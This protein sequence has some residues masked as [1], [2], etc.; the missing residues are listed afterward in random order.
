MLRLLIGESGTGKT[1]RI[2]E[3]IRTDISAG[4]KV[5]LIVPEQQTVAVERDMANDLPSDA[6][7]YFEAT[8][9]TRLCDTVFRKHGGL[10]HENIDPVAEQLLMWR[11]LNELSQLP[12]YQIEAEPKNIG[13]MCSIL[14]ELR[15]MKMD[16]AAL[17]LAAEK[18]TA[19]LSDKLR[20]YSLIFF[21]YNALL[22]E[23]DGDATDRLDKLA[24]QLHLHPF[25]KNTRFYIDN[26]SSYTAQEYAVIDA[27]L[28]HSD[29]T[30]S[31][32]MP[33]HVEKQ[34]S[35]AEVDTTRHTLLKLAGDRGVQTE[36]LTLETNHRLTAPVRAYLSENLFL[37]GD[38]EA[39]CC[40]MKNDP[41]LRLV[42]CPD[43]QDSCDYIASDISRRVQD[44]N[45][46]YS[47]F[48]II[49]GTASSYAGILDAALE[50][51]RVPFFFSREHDLMSFEPIKMTLLAYA[52]ITGGWRRENVVAYLKCAPLGIPDDA[53]DELELYAEMWNIQGKRWYDGKEWTMGPFGF[54]TPHTDGQKAYA[55][56]KLARVNAA[57]DI[58]TPALRQLSAIADGRH[59]VDEHIR[60][61]TSY[62]MSLPQS[63]PEYLDDRS[64]Q[65]KG[66]DLVRSDE[67]ARL[68][69]IICDVLDTMSKYLSDTSLSAEDFVMLLKMIFSVVSL[70]AIPARLDEVTVGEARMQRTGEV[71]HVYLLGANEGEFPSPPTSG[72]AFNDS[73]RAALYEAGITSF[74]AADISTSRELFS[75]WRAMNTASE[76]TTVIWSSVGLN[77]ES[78]TP[79]D[80]V[81]RM[82]RLL[83][84]SYPVTHI[85]SEDIIRNLT[86]P[87]AAGERIGQTNGTAVGDALARLLREDKAYQN[88]FSAQ[89]IPLCNSNLSLSEDT[90]RVQWPGNL[91]MTQSHLQ[92]LRECPFAFYCSFVLK[93]NPPKKAEFSSSSIGTFLHAVLENFF[94]EAKL[95]KIDL[96]NMDDAI[97]EELLMHAHEYVIN[98]TL[99]KDEPVTPR[100]KTL[101]S[102][103]EKHARAVISSLIDEMRHSSFTPAF[104]ELSID[105]KNPKTPAPVAFPLPDNK[106]IYV[107]GNIDRVDT[108]VEND[109][110]YIRVVDYKTGSKA[111]EMDDI[112][113]GLNLQLFLYMF[114]VAETKN[115]EFRRTLGISE[116]GEILPAAALYMSSLS[117]G[118]DVTT[119]LEN[120]DALAAAAEHPERLGLVLDEKEIISRLDDTADLHFLPLNYKANG[121]FDS[122]SRACL[123]TP[124]A[125]KELRAQIEKTLSELGTELKRGNIHASPMITKDADPCKYCSYKSVCRNTEPE[126]QAS[127]KTSAE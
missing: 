68:W 77:M 51:Y 29:I 40:P 87:I 92:K 114:S 36:I 56:Q 69:N 124:E 21:T 104:F 110:A 49:C 26:F 47:D 67:Y 53:R 32:C 74:D 1:T 54:G 102:S 2:I 45:L 79:S 10:A 66:T 126:R 106:K 107:Y 13:K 96:R 78:A 108:Y 86:S 18:C 14:K 60:A 83:G 91:A 120:E 113:A 27:L 25:D 31:L 61:L 70:G 72:Q 125:L 37:I 84:E 24:E 44:E 8:S 64:E 43:P 59:S 30:I 76:S 116:Q 35:G 48:A 112:K 41:A 23:N 101:L 6:P 63:L 20:A 127:E 71:K 98:E 12:G 7:L 11:C 109:K 33:H 58:L 93:L 75:F 5:F 16:P 89:E 73:E 46:K 55:E 65:F 103:L 82:K 85:T 97:R 100:T 115:E 117:T 50:K 118:A 34:L 123:T 80:A 52:I 3:Q 19:P 4:H 9:F 105:D 57:R 88:D 94:K 22:E 95:R 119:P 122:A 28:R 42:R 81:V 62:Y 39:M 38:T 90:A 111:F 15:G 121:D 17:S 99:P